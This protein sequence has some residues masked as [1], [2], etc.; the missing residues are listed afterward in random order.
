[1]SARDRFFAK[2]RKTETCWVW[3]AAIYGSGYGK[4]WDGEKVDGAHRV[5]YRL[6]VDEI[7][8]DNVVLHRCDNKLCVNPEHLDV[9]TQADNLQDMHKKGRQR[10]QE[11]YI[12]QSGDKAW[13]A[14]L[15]NLQAEAIRKEYLTGNTSWLKLAT[16]YGVAKRTIGNIVKGKTYVS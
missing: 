10:S 1:M 11:T 13:N 3:T 2:V 6:F 12:K 8:K 14:S 5:S 4:F 9:G 7:P 15:T 16:K